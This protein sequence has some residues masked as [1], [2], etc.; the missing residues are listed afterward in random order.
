V[1]FSWKADYKTVVEA[2]R[3]EL[4]ARGYR[5]ITAQKTARGRAEFVIGDWDGF[6]KSP[7][8]DTY[9]K[10]QLLYVLKGRAL[11]G[12]VPPLEDGWVTVHVVGLPS[13]GIFERLA[14]WI[15]L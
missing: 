3:S 6:V 7:S 1:Y 12:V 2:A 4:L 11:P 15:G 8:R 14:G 13:Q 10:L 5:D 9:R